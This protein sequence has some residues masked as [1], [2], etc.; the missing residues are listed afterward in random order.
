MKLL[1]K[2]YVTACDVMK[3]HFNRIK[4]YVQTF[5]EPMNR[6]N[7]VIIKVYE[8]GGVKLPCVRPPLG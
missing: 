8:K 6:L 2:I 3:Y 7:F 5:I 4:F 1:S